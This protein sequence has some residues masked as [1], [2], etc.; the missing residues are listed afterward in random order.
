MIKTWLKMVGDDMKLSDQLKAVDKNAKIKIY[1]TR[2][3]TLYADFKPYFI[4]E[5]HELRY[6]GKLS[7]L[8]DTVMYLELMNYDVVRVQVK[9]DEN[10]DEIDIYCHKAYK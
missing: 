8:D 2:I 7:G 5:T 6:S 4:T 1:K 3:D 10:C 9:Y